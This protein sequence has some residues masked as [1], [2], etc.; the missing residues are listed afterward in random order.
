M[1][2]YPN[3]VEL[4][5]YYPCGTGT[6]CDHA[7]IEPELLEAVL[8]GT[9]ALM[10]VEIMRLAQLY[11]CPAGILNHPEAIM[12]DMGR[13]KHQRMMK[14]VVSIHTQ[15]QAMAAGGNQKAAEYIELDEWRY[16]AFTFSVLGN[17]LSY[18]HYLGVKEV[19]QN[20]VSWST[21]AP[22]RRGIER[23]VLA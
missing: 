12:L 23:R 9:E 3:L 21:P 17:K 20:C 1:T 8:E 2:K 14:E 5:R 18:C 19:F 6:V 16:L 15:L 4:L 10:P 22:K 13:M 7:E 11:E